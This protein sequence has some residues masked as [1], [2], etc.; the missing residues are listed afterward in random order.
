MCGRKT[1]GEKSGYLGEELIE[2]GLEKEW[3]HYINRSSWRTKL[4]TNCKVRRRQTFFMRTGTR[5]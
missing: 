5:L 4:G 3:V 1:A 2:S